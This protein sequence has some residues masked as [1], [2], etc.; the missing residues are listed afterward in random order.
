VECKVVNGGGPPSQGTVSIVKMV[1]AEETVWAPSLGLRGVIDAVAVGKLNE[2]GDGPGPAGAA[3]K[4]VSTGM[5]PVVGR[6]RLTL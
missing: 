3:K 2:P 4:S 1:D 5:V 6:C